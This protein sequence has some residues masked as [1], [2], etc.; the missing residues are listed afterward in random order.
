M[1][2]TMQQ[3]CD[4]LL[5]MKSNY[6]SSVTQSDGGSLLAS[7][8]TQA[9]NAGGADV[10]AGLSIR[11]LARRT[12]VSA[13]QISRIESGQVLK[14]SREILVALGRG[15]NRNPLPLLIL[16]GHL[17]VSEAREALGP[18]FREG[19]ELPEE[20][21]P[22][23]VKTLDA[24]RSVLADPAASEP[25]VRMIAADVFR[26]VETDE[27]LWDESYALALARGSDAAE[28]RDLMTIWRFVGSRRAELLEYGRSLRR[29][30]DLEYQAEAS[31]IRAEANVAPSTK[32]N[33]PEEDS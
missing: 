15:L 9:R 13:A 18:L 17:T 19:S 14:P 27:T 16:A 21:G 4:C 25:D 29:L 12:G 7:V 23:A 5:R 1:R 28:L 31:A 6:A 11:E 2:L 26:I 32:P 8:L 3:R 33:D 24:A 30:A 20:W 10:P 22:W